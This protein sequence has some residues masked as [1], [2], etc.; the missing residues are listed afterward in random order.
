MEHLNKFS[1]K[2]LRK[3]PVEHETQYEQQCDLR[4]T[5]LV[6]VISHKGRSV[7]KRVCLWEA[8]R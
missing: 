8:L 5:N 3:I 1:Y 7:G 4:P 6:S 2:I